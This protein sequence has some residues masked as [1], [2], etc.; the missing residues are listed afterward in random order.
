MPDL[1]SASRL[2]R[3]DVHSAIGSLAALGV[4]LDRVD[5]RYEAGG[6][7][8]RVLAQ[9]PAPGT[10]LHATSRT[11][12]RIA[13]TG[14]L[15]SVPYVLRDATEPGQMAV[16]ALAEVLDT[17]LIRARLFVQSAGGHFL[18]QP[19]VPV[20]ALRWIQEVMRL[21][22]SAWSQSE[23][24]RMARLLSVLPTI[25]GRADAVG[26]A[27]RFVFG[28]PVSEP[29]L[30]YARLP[31]RDAIATR[32]GSWNGRLGVD[33]VVGNGLTVPHQLAIRIGP[34]PLKTY[35]A[36]HK[37]EAARTALYRL[38]LPTFLPGGVRERW[39]V[40]PRG[41]EYRLGS[42]EAP[43]LLGASSYLS[44]APSPMAAPES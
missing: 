26:T 1:V 31:M 44:T 30:R 23:W 20:T 35:L 41:Q 9:K 4:S 38:L 21:D 33:A 42:R 36:Q 22:A 2:F 7:P 3:H 5:L 16:D 18:L 34:V 12:L 27:L 14:T 25:A 10:T 15:Y 32:L 24:Y 13:G 37:R 39:V 17:S 29:V 43:A 11:E 28:L 19:G 40:E 6:E 8:G